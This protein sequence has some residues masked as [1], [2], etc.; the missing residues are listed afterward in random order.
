M[1][2]AIGMV[3]TNSVGAGI[4][5]TDAMLK[6]ANVEVIYSRP[7]CPGKY[8]VLVSGRV[9]DI[10][11]SMQAGV[12][13]TAGT[14]VDTLIL[15]NVHPS[16]APA[17]K[18]AT[19]IDG[20]KALGVLESFSVASLVVAADMAVKAAAVILIEIRTAIA[21]GGK[22]YCTLTGDESSVQVAVKTGAEY[23]R[24]QGALVSEI[25]IAR[26]HNEILPFLL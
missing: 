26:P 20:L 21:L 7:V 19:S 6:R 25:V 4:E 14:L 5:A 15:P 17:L 24:S 12:E 8:L 9:S 1:R 22:A 16:I 11:A 13:K 23:L 3:E 18:Q 2:A 10:E